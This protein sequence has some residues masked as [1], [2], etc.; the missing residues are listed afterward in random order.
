[1]R[2]PLLRQNPI[3]INQGTIVNWGLENGPESGY[4]G[5]IEI[6]SLWNVNVCVVWG[7]QTY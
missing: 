1:M 6:L 3:D 7:V 4:R 5:T 2:A